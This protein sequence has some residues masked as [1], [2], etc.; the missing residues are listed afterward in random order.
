[1]L[2]VHISPHLNIVNLLNYIAMQY[3][4]IKNIYF[5]P[6]EST[7][8]HKTRARHREKINHDARANRIAYII[9]GVERVARAATRNGEKD[10][11]FG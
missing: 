1:M 5:N 8:T 6:V 11:F 10:S 9:N 3:A 7:H 4:M 2:T